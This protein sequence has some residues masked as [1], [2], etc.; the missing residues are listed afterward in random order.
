MTGKFP[1]QEIDHIDGDGTNNRWENLREA[2]RA[3]NN[4]N[5]RGYNKC[6]IKG[7]YQRGPSWIAQIS[8]NGGRSIHLG[9]FRTPEEAH[10]A[11]LAAAHKYFGEFANGGGPCPTK[12]ASPSSS[13]LPSISGVQMMPESSSE[14]SENISETTAQIPEDVRRIVTQLQKLGVPV[15]NAKGEPITTA[16]LAEL[17]KEGLL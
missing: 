6:G 11:Y 3:Q 1:E 8:P 4:A 7:V 2:T 9:C 15:I 10:A 14:N 16:D 13:I 5:C 17:V 12:P